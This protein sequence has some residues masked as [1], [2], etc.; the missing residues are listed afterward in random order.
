MNPPDSS[1]PLA[2]PVGW[3]RCRNPARAKF[4]TTREVQSAHNPGVSWRQR[5]ALTVAAS[6]DRLLAELKRLGATSGIIS[7]NIRTR[8]DGQPMGKAAEPVD[9]GAAVYFR[10]KGEPRVLAC[11]RW[12]RV[13][14]NLAALAKHIEAIRGQVRWGVGSLDQAFGGYRALPAMGAVR[15]WSE[16][17]G[18]PREAS[19][20]IVEARRVELL[21]RHHPD[22]GGSHDRAAEVNEAADQACRE[23]A[24]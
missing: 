23:L 10:L 17:L 4:G 13:A 1:F 12:D 2:W 18:V 16:I 24:T 9:S 8:L 5:G 21:T 19:V 11:D 14:D 15:H 6:R 7:T 3:P 22:R 20:E